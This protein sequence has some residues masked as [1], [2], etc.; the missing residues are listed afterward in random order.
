MET[1]AKEAAPQEATEP[2]K[3]PEFLH[4]KFNSTAVSGPSD[5][6]K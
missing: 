2:K 4:L 6:D 5:I 3:F 1:T